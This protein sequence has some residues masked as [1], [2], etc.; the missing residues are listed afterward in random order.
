MWPDCD[1]AEQALVRAAEDADPG[2][3]AIARE[4]QVVLGVDEDAG[5]AGKV[6]GSARR[7]RRESQSSTS[8]RSAP[9]CATYMRLRP[10]DVGVVEPGLGARRDRDEAGSLEAHAA[11]ATSFRHQA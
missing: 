3:A 10:V 11:L 4:E 1:P 2:G 8:I 6:T 9:V 5:D 7:Y